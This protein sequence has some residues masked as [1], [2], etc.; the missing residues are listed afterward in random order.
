[1]A[2][3]PKWPKSPSGPRAQV[4][5]EPKW[6]KIPSGPSAQVVA[7]VLKSPTAQQPDSPTTQQPNNP[8]A[9]QPPRVP[10]R[11]HGHPKS[12]RAPQTPKGPPN[13]QEPNFPS[14]QEPNSPTAQQ[15][16]SPIMIPHESTGAQEPQGPQ[17]KNICTLLYSISAQSVKVQSVQWINDI[18]SNHI[19]RLGSVA[20]PVIQATGRSEFEDGLGSG[21]FMSGY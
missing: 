7:Q 20:G 4:A 5:Q 1:V 6:P 9:Q 19:M 15:P 14:A 16:N 2:Q 10:L 8:T 3:E 13:D 17:L 21:D 11:V 12:P 18:I